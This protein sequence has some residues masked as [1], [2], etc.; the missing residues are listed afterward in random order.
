MSIRKLIVVSMMSLD[1]FYEG[2]EGDL[3]LL[4]F[5]G[6]AFNSYNLERLQMA[7]TVLLGGKSYE[8]FK[9]Y[10]PAVEHDTHA[11]SVSREFSRIYNTVDKVVVSD[12]ASLP[13]P[14][15][16]WSMNTR[17]LRRAEAHEE[18]AK[19]KRQGDGEIVMWGSRTL[20]TDLLAHGLVDELHL[21]IGAIAVGN[22]IP[23]F[24]R[25][26]TSLRF[27]DSRTFDGSDDVLIRYRVPGNE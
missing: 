26:A 22:G 16:P 8:A 18:I 10:W 5:D 13:E 1:G 23:L 2:P 21:M 9:G 17:L 11:P 20:W 12:H 27:M 24:E 14:G 7:D 4:P 15:H 19:L 25:R 6:G 3:M